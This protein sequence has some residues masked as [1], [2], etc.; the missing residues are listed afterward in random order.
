MKRSLLK[1]AAGVSVLLAGAR[2]ARTQHVT[3]LDERLFRAVNGFPDA[4]QGPG[5]VVMQAGS[6][7]AV[8]AAAGGALAIERRGL[9]TRFAVAGATMWLGAKAAKHLIGRG[10]PGDLLEGVTIRGRAQ[11]G[12]GYPSGHAA[13]SAA[14]AVVAARTWPQ[15]AVG[16]AAVALVTALMRIYDGAHFPSDVV[17]GAAAGLA[18][19]T[20][21]NAIAA[22]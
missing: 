11:S 13:V 10:R 2:Q 12:L 15:A 17:G 14:L 4:L 8:I 5:W 19:G 6:L 9:A 21:V 1:A 7:G 18:A 3:G 22:R 16:L 20:I